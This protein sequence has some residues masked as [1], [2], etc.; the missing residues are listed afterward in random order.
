MKMTSMVRPLLVLMLLTT[1]GCGDWSRRQ[2]RSGLMI[3]PAD[4]ARLGYVV[5]WS[6]YLNVPKRHELSSV[7]LLG[8]LLFT[9][10]APGNLVSAIS[11]RDGKVLWRREVGE[12]TENVYP[13]VR[14]EERVYFNNDTTMFTIGITHGDLIATAELA[15][16]VETGP[17][18]IDRYAIF[19]GA[20]GL[21]FAHDLDAGYTKWSYRMTSGIVVSPAASQQNVFVADSKGI[22]ASLRASSGELVFRGRTFGPVTASSA[23]T[24]AGIYIPSYDQSLYALDRVT[25]RDTWVYRTATPLT[26]AP[27]AFGQTVYLPLPGAGIVALSAD[28]GEERWKSDLRRAQAVHAKGGK[29]LL[30]YPGGLRWIDEKSGRVVEDVQTMPLQTIIPLPEGGLVI[31][32]PGGRVHRLNAKR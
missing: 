16:V 5:N 26:Q 15:Q 13:P 27:A 25:G 32:S 28:D 10:E 9:V 22:Y 2:S 11:V 24:R 20:D 17:V 23:S 21:V 29:A 7:T 30:L 1:V 3:E 8:D 4:A 31:V 14:D 6:T 19:G 18:L 12:P